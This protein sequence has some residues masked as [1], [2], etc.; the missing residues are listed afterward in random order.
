MSSSIRAHPRLRCAIA[1]EAGPTHRSWPFDSPRGPTAAFVDSH[2]RP[3][4]HALYALQ[5]LLDLCGHAVTAASRAPSDKRIVASVR[6]RR[7]TQPGATAV[8]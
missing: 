5:A 2:P 8:L 4:G 7:T 3:T 1:L 6:Q